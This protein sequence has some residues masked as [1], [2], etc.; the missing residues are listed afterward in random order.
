MTRHCP[1]LLLLLTLTSGLAQEPAADKPKPTTRSLRLLPL[2]E[3]PPFLQEVRD[4]VRYELEPEAG[5]IPPREVLLGD[6]ENAAKIRLNL[7][8]A[9]GAEKLPLGTA[10][11][12]LRIPAATTEAPPTPWLTIRPPETGD[13]LALIWRDP[14]KLWAAPRTLVLPDSA[15]AFPAGNIR[16]V[17]LLPVE[18]ALVFGAD[19]V[20]VAPGKTLMRAVKPLVDVAIQIAYK[21]PT[22]QFQAFYSGSLLLAP[23]ERAQVFLHRADGEKPR[24][25]AKVV[26]FNEA[27]PMAPIPNP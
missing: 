8:R 15:A 27:T 11:A 20:R 3:P 22:G 9:T 23:N 19:E 25:P 2:G 13:V 6:G 12:M 10:P 5:S 18:T 21:A 4:G 1:L 16:I 17:N 24:R 26:I 14:G 7:G